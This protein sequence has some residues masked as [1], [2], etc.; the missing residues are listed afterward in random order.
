MPSTSSCAS[1]HARPS[2]ALVETTP[3]PAARVAS[4][5][6]VRNH[7]LAADLR[8]LADAA[9]YGQITGIAYAVLLPDGTTKAGLLADADANRPLAHYA[10][11]RLADLT[12]WPEKYRPRPRPLGR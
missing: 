8:A 12:L 1:A 4:I 7:Q 11:S 10:V 5:N 2:L 6:H 3:A 9:E